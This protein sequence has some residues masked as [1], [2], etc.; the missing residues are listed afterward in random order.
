MGNLNNVKGCG[1][2]LITPFKSNG[3][4]DFDAIN[5]LVDRQLEEGINFLVPCGTTGES[6]TL[7]LNEHL[8]VIDTVIKRVDRKV[9]VI[10]GAGGYN[11]IKTI[12]MAK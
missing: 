10:G 5:R 3:D 2:A 6:A 11:T 4:L 9:P 1:T 8:G 12:E 7:S